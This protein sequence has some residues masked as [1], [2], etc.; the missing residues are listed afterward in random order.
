MLVNILIITSAIYLTLFII[1]VRL[2]LGEY[3]K[4]ISDTFYRLGEYRNAFLFLMIL[5]ATTLLIT[6]YSEVST[7]FPYMGVGALGIFGVGTFACFKFKKVGIPHYL[8]ALIGFGFSIMSFGWVIGLII[9]GIGLS[10]LFFGPKRTKTFWLEVV[11]AY[12]LLLGI[13]YLQLLKI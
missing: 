7:G 1:A 13:T 11:L 12:G 10:S 2:Y 4:S 6:G 5:S 3:P 8:A 9:L